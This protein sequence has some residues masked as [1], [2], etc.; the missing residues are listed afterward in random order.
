[1]MHY[2]AHW[3]VLIVVPSSL[4]KQ[5]PD[6]ILSYAGDVVN[7]ADIRCIGSSSQMGTGLITI[8]T[9]KV[10]DNLVANKLLSPEQF[11]V[12][13]ADESHNLKNKDS[14]RS[15]AVIPFLKKATIALCMTGTLPV[16]A[17]VCVQF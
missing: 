6:E 4:M 14:Q 8:I 2:R 17:A 3:P 5:W 12:V 16:V 7:R 11:G 9:Y 10:M 13:I 1:M 15:L